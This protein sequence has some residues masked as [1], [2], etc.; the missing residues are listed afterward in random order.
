MTTGISRPEAMASLQ[1]SR[2]TL[3]RYCAELWY[4]GIHYCKHVQK[5]LYNRELLEDWMVNRHEWGVH[6]RAIELYQAS[7]P[8]NQKRRNAG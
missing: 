6:L 7:L 4:L 5:I 2:R 8:S 3:S 1:I